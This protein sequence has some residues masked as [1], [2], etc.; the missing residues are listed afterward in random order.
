MTDQVTVAV[1]SRA[2]RAVEQVADVAVEMRGRT[3]EVYAV[4]RGRFP[5]TFDHSFDSVDRTAIVRPAADRTAQP[6]SPPASQAEVYDALGRPLVDN[7]LMGYNGC[8]IAYGPTGSGKTFSIFG[9]PGSIGKNEE[10]LLPRVCNELFA[11][12]GRQSD[13]GTLAAPGPIIAIGGRNVPTQSTVRVA[14]LE[15]YL[16]E[17]YDLL[18]QRK[19]LVVRHSGNG[20]FAVPGL[21]WREVACYGDI[22]ELLREADAYKT[23]AATNVHQRS[24][25]AHT[26]FYVELRMSTVDVTRTSRIVLAD[27][28]GSEK[29][30]EAGTDS[31]VGLREATSINTSLLTLGTCIEAAVRHARKGAK[32]SEAAIGEF[33][34]SAL[35]K[36]LREYIGGN[37]RTAVLV[38]VSP[39]L[40]EVSNTLQALRFAD[41]AKQ[42]HNHAAVNV[43]SVNPLVEKRVHATYADRRRSLEQECEM[44]TKYELHANRATQLEGTLATLVHRAASSDAAIRADAERNKLHVLM[45]LGQVRT[46]MDECEAALCALRDENIALLVG[47][48]VCS[49]GG[50]PFASTPGTPRNQV[51]AA[52]AASREVDHLRAALDALTLERDEESA[53]KAMEIAALRAEYEARLEATVKDCDSAVTQSNRCLNTAVDQLR[54]QLEEERSAGGAR[55][56]AAEEDCVTSRATIVTLE[57]EVSNVRRQLRAAFDKATA[58]SD[59]ALAAATRAVDAEREIEGATAELTR[60]K[61]RAD[62][63][64]ALNRRA[65]A[66]IASLKEERGRLREHCASLR[67]C[68]ASLR[69]DLDTANAE[70]DALRR[71]LD[72]AAADA[73][74]ELADVQHSA[75]SRETRTRAAA[76]QQ[77]AAA[78]SRIADLERALGEADVTQAESEEALRRLAAEQESTS[79]ALS[80]A[81]ADLQ[82]ARASEKTAVERAEELEA[83]IRQQA[84]AHRVELGRVEGDANE[85]AQRL[86]TLQRLHR[87]EAD[88]VVHTMTAQCIAAQKALEAALGSGEAYRASVAAAAANNN[89]SASASPVPTPTAGSTTSTTPS[90]SFFQSS[91]QPA[92]ATRG[93]DARHH[94]HHDASTTRTPQQAR[95]SAVTAELAETP[96]G[97]ASPP[98][99]GTS[100]F[101]GPPTPTFITSPLARKSSRASAAQHSAATDCNHAA[102]GRRSSF[103]SDAVEP[104]QPLKENEGLV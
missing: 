56:L 73:R 63:Y 100:V 7:A 74:A 93:S 59:E 34:N 82:R 49:S 1:R 52:H 2:L 25:R 14:A 99:R 68:T 72:R 33:R 43:R 95:A 67:D 62:E 55:L 39:T 48:P 64:E 5:F 41:R 19:A 10:G 4:N 50:M 54:R 71:R 29:I 9:P 70:L 90:S 91:A 85:R 104:L 101:G 32:A 80:R 35:T 88:N 17:V 45:E 84:A 102:G 16:D 13:A 92:R 103:H 3:I 11:R 8:I 28:A 61:Q 58:Q 53:M 66:D 96:P 47:T 79:E 12:L 57:E 26:L 76:E 51:S 36:L 97:S 87:I 23:F 86:E 20:R 94:L 78:E 44:E 38:T 31:G 21:L 83:Q 81:W 22:V 60:T 37:S 69:H 42:L 27:L 75:E 6:P 65:Q 40:G 30:K 98:P 24:S 89:N 15:I 18:A 77:L 46:A